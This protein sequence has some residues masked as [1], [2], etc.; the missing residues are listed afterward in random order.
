[1]HEERDVPDWLQI[2]ALLRLEAGRLMEDASVE[3]ALSLSRADRIRAD[4]LRND[5]EIAADIQTLLAAARVLD[6]R[7]LGTCNT[8]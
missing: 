6:R 7:C 4:R 1:M 3:L 8:E 5:H 2:I